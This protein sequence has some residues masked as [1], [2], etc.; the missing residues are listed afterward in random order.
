MKRIVLLLLAAAVPFFAWSKSSLKT[1]VYGDSELEPEDSLT[2]SLEEMTD[3]IGGFEVL[4]EYLP[5]MVDVMW[6]G[7]K[8]KT[9][10][11]GKVKYSKKDEDF[12]A[13]N[14]ENPAGL[15][16]SI[17]KKSGKVKGSFKVYVAKSEKKLKSYTAKFTGSLGGN[18]VVTIK[19]VG[20][21]S[22]SLE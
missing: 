12:V 21:F 10:K 15:K 2:F 1:F 5:D 19:G 22:A 9:P 16:I 18:I 4:S 6:T 14:D 13:T 8:F 20:S 7:K 17:N 3:E 11:A